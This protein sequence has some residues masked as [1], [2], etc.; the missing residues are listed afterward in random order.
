MF[1]VI[2]LVTAR[3]RAGSQDGVATFSTPTVMHFAAALLV[4]ALL[5]APWHSLRFA[6]A[7]VALLGLYGLAYVLRIMLQTKRLRRYT[8]DL[9][10]WTWYTILPFLAYGAICA[11]A[12]V[13]TVDALGNALFVIGSG[14]V[15]LIFL[16]IRNAWDIV[17]FLA[18]HGE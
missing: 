2:S 4:S 16:G 9:E 3:E 13:L 18:V 7:L 10:D 6:G 8:A 11:G 5:I 15:L 14:V 17:T 1:V 12:V